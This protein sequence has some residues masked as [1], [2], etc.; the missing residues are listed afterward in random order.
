MDITTII[1]LIVALGAISVGYLLEG[2]SFAALLAISPIL[3]IFGGTIGVVIITQPAAIL[4]ETPKLFVKLF[5][6]TKYDY[7]DLIDKLTTWSKT[8]RTQGVIAL[9]SITGDIEDPFIKRGLSYVIDSIE[10]EH[11]KT[12]LEN[13]IESMQTR[14]AKNASIFAAAGGFAPTMG[15]IGTVLGL[16]V[17]LAGLGDSTMA[18]LGHGIATAFLATFMGVGI[19]NLIFLPFQDKLK[20]KSKQEVL[21]REIAMYGILAIQSQESPLVLKKRLETLLGDNMKKKEA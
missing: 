16:I 7:L 2:G 11:V 12:F 18:E 3:I 17:V 13:E 10:P 19:A 21:Y 4:K 1:G 15:V 5:T 9:E 20:N 6:D 8:A 14:H